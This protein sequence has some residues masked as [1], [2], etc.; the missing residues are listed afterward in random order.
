MNKGCKKY[1]LYSEKTSKVMNLRD[2]AQRINWHFSVDLS[3]AS[4]GLMQ[5]VTKI[6]KF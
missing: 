5:G 4:S 3:S 6:N 2:I 1:E